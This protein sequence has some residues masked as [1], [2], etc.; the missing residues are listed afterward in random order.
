MREIG[1]GMGLMLPIFACAVL[2]FDDVM[3]SGL[4]VVRGWIGGVE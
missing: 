1:I 4:M 2:C 3:D